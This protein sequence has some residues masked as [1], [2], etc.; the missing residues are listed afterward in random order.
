MHAVKSIKHIPNVNRIAEGRVYQRGGRD[1][2]MGRD[3]CAGAD[4]KLI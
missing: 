4:E 2:Q 3:H 1:L